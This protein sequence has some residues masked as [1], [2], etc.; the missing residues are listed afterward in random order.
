[1]TTIILRQPTGD[2][3]ESHLVYFRTNWADAWTAAPYV[4]AEE[5]VWST[6]PQISTARLWWDYGLIKRY[7]QPQA[8]IVQKFRSY[9]RLWVKIRQTTDAGTSYRDWFGSVELVEDQQ[10]GGFYSYV[11]ESRYVLPTGEQQI[12]AYG[13]EGILEMETIRSSVYTTDGATSHI[14]GRPLTFNRERINPEPGRTTKRKGNR[15]Q[16]AAWSGTHIFN[17]DA[18]ELN[19]WSTRDIVRYLLAWTT[20]TGPDGVRY[21]SWELADSGLTG[22]LADWDNPEVDEEY[23]SVWGI[24]TSLMSR[25]RLVGF[26][27]AV[28]STV[29]PAKAQIKPFSFAATAVAHAI[30]GSDP[31]PAN[32]RK[33]DLVIEQDRTAAATLK[34]SSLEQYDAVIVRGRRRRSCFSISLPDGTLSAGWTSDL[35]TLYEA[36]ASTVTGYAGFELVEQ[37]ERNAEV[38]GG[39]LLRDVFQRFVIPPAWD[40]LSGDGEGSATQGPVFPKTDTSTLGSD[41]A[42]FFR[43]DLEMLATLPLHE[44]VDYSGDKIKDDLVDESAGNGRERPPLCV[45]KLP[46]SGTRRWQTIDTVGQKADLEETDDVENTSWSA[47]VRTAEDGGAVELIVYGAPQHVIAETDFTPLAADEDLG[48]N[49]WRECIITVAVEDDRYAEGSYGLGLGDATDLERIKV[50]DAG[51]E[52]CKDWVAIWTVVGVNLDGTLQRSTGGF[53]RDDTPYLAEIAKLAY[54]WY[55]IPRHSLIFETE[56]L[57]SAIELGDM[58]ENLNLPAEGGN[59]LNSH[60]HA[61]INTV[62]TE[63]RIVNPRADDVNPEP[64][65]MQITTGAGELDPMILLGR[66]PEPTPVSWGETRGVA[67]PPQAAAGGGRTP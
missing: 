38:R 11:G 8:A 31:I 55:S 22:L 17:A 39:D 63:I 47:R 21:L 29:S 2:A 65:R 43:L 36:A 16:L 64:A 50:I 7:D 49:D 6:A 41:S 26:R 33:F 14:C 37:Q 61:A 52:Y 23:R 54:A 18:D 30:A 66:L 27:V 45:W 60:Y 5:I 46:S 1:M 9:Q 28:D 24:L 10:Q 42:P 12:T 19:D 51:D 48:D 44:G 34:I 15:T 57:T 20:P 25:H 4:W 67:M 13:L 59:P 3:P 62:V 40:G 58:V 53:V 56:H 32:N 35:E